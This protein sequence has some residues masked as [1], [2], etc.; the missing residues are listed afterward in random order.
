MAN[1][2]PAALLVAVC[3]LAGAT[4]QPGAAQ[5]TCRSNVLGAE[6]CVGVPA[7]EPR[8]RRLFPPRRFGLGAVQAS[9]GAESGPKLTPAGRSDVLGNTFLTAR[10]LPPDR[11]L[12]GVA[13]PRS[14]ARD[15]LG[16]LVC[17]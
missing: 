10:D 11:P 6:T 8:A 5:V 7:P 3:M 17:R 16:N 15:A 1:R 2:R 12:P 4:A 14:C 13:A 9:P